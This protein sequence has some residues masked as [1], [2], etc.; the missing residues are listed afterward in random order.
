[1]TLSYKDFVEYSSDRSLSINNLCNDA[2]ANNFWVEKTSLIHEEI[3]RNK[4]IMRMKYKLYKKNIGEEENLIRAMIKSKEKCSDE[5][6]IRS[7]NIQADTNAEY[8]KQF[9]YDPSA[10]KTSNFEVNERIGCN[11][12]NNYK[13]HTDYYHSPEILAVETTVTRTVEVRTIFIFYILMYT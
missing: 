1:M 5:Y 2:I 10:S 3:E 9:D 11:Y 6:S 7:N 13:Q 4:T 12:S 8:S